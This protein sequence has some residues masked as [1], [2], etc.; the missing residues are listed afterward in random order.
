MKTLKTIAV[1]V[2]L[3]GCA[4]QPEAISGSLHGTESDARMTDPQNLDEEC[5]RIYQ[6]LPMLM[7]AVMMEG[8][9]DCGHPEYDTEPVPCDQFDSEEEKEARAHRLQ[10]RKMQ[11]SAA[12]EADSA[13]RAYEEDREDEILRLRAEEAIARAR[14][15]DSGKL[16]DKTE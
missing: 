11:E 1:C 4:S 12:R 7:L 5:L 6:V 2:L 15:T 8:P 10:V 14:D 3:A 9:M 16:P 13:C